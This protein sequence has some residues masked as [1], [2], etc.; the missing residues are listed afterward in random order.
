MFLDRF[1][2]IV[3]KLISKKIIIW[4]I[5]ERKTLWKAT[6]GTLSNT[7]LVQSFYHEKQL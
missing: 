3:P 6:S 4:Y 2:V 7:P 5:S 1:D